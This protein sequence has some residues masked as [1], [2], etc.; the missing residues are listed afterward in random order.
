MTAIRCRFRGSSTAEQHA[1]Q[2]PAHPT[3][4]APERNAGEARAEHTLRAG[5]STFVA[6]P[7][8]LINDHRTFLDR[9]CHWFLGPFRRSAR[10]YGS[11]SRA[12]SRLR[13]GLR[14]DKRN[15]RERQK[16]RGTACKPEPS[17][18]SES[19]RRGRR[20]FST[21]N[22]AWVLPNGWPPLLTASEAAAGVRRARE[23]ADAMAERGAQLPGAARIGRR[24]VVRRDD[25]LLWQDKRRRASLGGEIKFSLEEN[26]ADHAARLRERF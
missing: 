8:S 10:V 13:N 1:R 12:A 16:D 26:P 5:W 3:T 4:V 23:A 7:W 18:A 22:R 14:M 6:H 21:Q 24:L 9:V 25:P 20:S 19:R 11:E 15:I 17:G 2:R